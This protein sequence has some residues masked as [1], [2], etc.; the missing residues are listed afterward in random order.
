MYRTNLCTPRE[1]REG[2]MN[3]DVGTNIYTLLYTT[4]TT[5]E[6]LL[7]TTGNSTQCSVVTKW[8]GNPKKRGYVCV[9]ACVYTQI[10]IAHSLFCTAENNTTL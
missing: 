7:Y 8:E 5:N 1:E 6:N 3:G 10:Q 4:Y 9:H 2:G